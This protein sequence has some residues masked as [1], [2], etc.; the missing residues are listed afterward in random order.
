M[1]NRSEFWR[2]LKL[3]GEGRLHPTIDSVFPLDRIRDAH[4]RAESRE[5]F[6][7][8]IVMV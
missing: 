5:S 6:G 3:V 8:I 7:K 4:R 1:G 2:V